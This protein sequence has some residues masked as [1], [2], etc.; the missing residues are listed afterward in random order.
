MKKD[1]R[2]EFNKIIN[3]SS[4][5]KVELINNYLNNKF[6]KEVIGFASGFRNKESA[7]I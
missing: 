1:K 4:L 7:R 3:S 6:H 5:N 2:N